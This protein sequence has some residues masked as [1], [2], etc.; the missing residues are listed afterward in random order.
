MKDNWQKDIHNRLGNYEINEP[1]GL[2]ED[3]RKEMAGA[4]GGYV[5]NSKSSVS[6]RIRR[7]AS[8]AA[9]A[10]VALLLGY[11]IYSKYTCSE[12]DASELAKQQ[13]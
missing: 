2:W 7:T 11:S 10:S 1:E 13:L 5:R 12:Q 3:I 8:V 9:A 6:L 4:N